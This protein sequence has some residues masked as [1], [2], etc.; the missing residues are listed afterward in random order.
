[1]ETLEE[2]DLELLQ[3]FTN[4]LEKLRQASNAADKLHQIC[5]AMCDVACAYRNDASLQRSYE[6]FSDEFEMY[7]NQ[8]GLMSHDLAPLYD[9]SAETLEWNFGNRSMFD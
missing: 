2:R 6:G 9:E 7:L 8:F 5:K 3:S 4:S 1:M